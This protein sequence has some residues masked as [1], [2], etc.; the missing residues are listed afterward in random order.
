MARKLYPDKW[1]FAPT[2][3]LALFGVV[4]VY[5]AS[6]IIAQHESG[7]QF[8]YVIKQA[9]WTGIGF[10]AMVAMMLVDYRRLQDRR[11][12]FGLITLTG[13]MLLAVFLFPRV[14]GAHRWLRVDGLSIQPSEISKLTLAI[15]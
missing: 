7:N 15:L 12:V 11:V 4:M 13:T 2:A 6:A 1:L 9:I 14:N 3:G 10:V 8:Y 5:S